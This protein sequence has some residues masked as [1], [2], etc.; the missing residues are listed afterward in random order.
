MNCKAFLAISLPLIL[1]HTADRTLAEEVTPGTVVAVA[2]EYPDVAL[3]AQV[4]GSVA[5]RVEIDRKGLVRSATVVS[6]HPLL[7]KSAEAAARLWEF[8]QAKNSA[9]AD[10]QLT[11]VYNLLPSNACWQ[12]TLARFLP[13]DRINVSRRRVVPSCQ[14]CGP[15][16]PIEYERCE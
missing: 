1:G 12:K 15:S 10:R 5:V 9:T 2:P 8:D 13:P 16:K 14:D 11:F 4:E 3:Q 6:G 7:T